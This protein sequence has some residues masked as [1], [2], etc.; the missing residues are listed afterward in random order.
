MK[1][2]LSKDG[3]Y[4]TILLSDEGVYK[5]MTVHRMVA[6]TFLNPKNKKETVNHKNGI[7]TDNRASNLEW[8]TRKENVIHSFK[9]GLQPK[10]HGELNGCNKVTEK[11]V[12]EIRKLANNG[13]RFYGRKE[14]SE[15]YGISED[16]I[17]RIV[18]RKT[19]K[20]I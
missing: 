8:M 18:N 13:Q 2:A 16:S 4:K 5:P 6:I 14:L 1:P 10:K 19:W 20:H 7:K 12:L 9:N 3:Y 15:K 11:E 17:K